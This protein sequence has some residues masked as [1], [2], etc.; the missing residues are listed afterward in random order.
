MELNASENS[1]VQGLVLPLGVPGGFGCFDVRFELI[2]FLL[3]D[4]F[5]L[6]NK[7]G[8]CL[9]DVDVLCG[10]RLSRCYRDGALT[11]DDVTTTVSLTSLTLAS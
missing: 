2:V 7:L 8:A 9:L 5:A 4:S 1:P 11:S 10:V 6:A 3:G